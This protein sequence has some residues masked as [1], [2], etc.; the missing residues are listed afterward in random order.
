MA[1]EL[2]KRDN[3]VDVFLNGRFFTT[4][5]NSPEFKAPFMGPVLTK[6]G[7]NFTRP[8]LRHREH[9]HQ[10]SVFIGIG[11]IN[12]YDFWNERA[13]PLGLI[14]VQDVKISPDKDKPVVSLKSLWQGRRGK[15]FLDEE[16]SYT[17]SEVSDICVRVD[18]MLKL[19]ANYGDIR[20]GST[21]EAGPLGIRVAD[22]IRVKDG[23]GKFTNSEG[24]I[25]EEGCWGKTARWC[26][27]SGTVDGKQIGIA[28]FDHPENERYPTAWHIR[29]YGLMAA[30]NLYFKGGFKM[31]KGE[32]I[33]YKFTL[34]FWENSF[35]PEEL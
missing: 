8:E 26:N 20:F 10:R 15:R 21:K 12:R 5:V 4:C 13:V 7:F 1:F 23:T 33:T 27:Y 32:S 28:A 35:N 9:P 11:D 2:K 31:K 25:N 6:D 30:N 14:R 18:I 34:C 16:R 17:F 29:D 24:G 3:D 19:T 22:E